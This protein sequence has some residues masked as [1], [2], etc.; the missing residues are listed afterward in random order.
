MKFCENTQCINHIEVREGAQK[1]ATSRSGGV[2]EINRHR[3]VTF[4]Q[5]NKDIKEEVN[6]CDTCKAAIE[7]FRGMEK[8]VKPG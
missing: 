7:I 6:L 2:V 3:L 4:D 5:T 1:L 8:R